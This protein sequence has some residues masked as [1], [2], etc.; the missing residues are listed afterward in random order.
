MADKANGSRIAEHKVRKRYR[1]GRLWIVGT[2]YH[3]DEGQV[4]YADLAGV[5]G[6]DKADGGPPHA[7]RYIT[8][9]ADPYR[10]PSMDLEHLIFEFDAYRAYLQG[11][12]GPET[13][14]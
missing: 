5:L 1:F 6:D 14:R 4:R 8:A 3:T 7:A 9:D 12:L 2:H 13:L 10:L 11:A